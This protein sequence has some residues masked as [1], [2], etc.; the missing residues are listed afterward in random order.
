MSAKI[1]HTLASGWS[2]VNSSS[3]TVP[4]FVCPARS[5]WRRAGAGV[6]AARNGAN[7]AGRRGGAGRRL[8]AAGHLSLPRASSTLNTARTMPR[9]PV[10]RHR[11]PD[12]STRTRASS[13]SGTRSTRSRAAISMPGVQKPHCSACSWLNALRNSAIVASS[14]KPSIVRTSWPSQPTANAMHERA[15]TPSI[16]TVQAPHTPCSQPRWVPVSRWCSRRKS[17]EGGR[18]STRAFNRPSR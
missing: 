11:L 15:G 9:Y 1:A 3:I 10:H 17:A 14:S 12:I 2:T 4:G 7:G 16:S 18:G 6:A 13:A 8:A 5:R